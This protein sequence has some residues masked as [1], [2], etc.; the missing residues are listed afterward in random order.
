MPL[1]TITQDV[2]QAFKEDCKRN[3]KHILT[4][5]DVEDKSG[6]IKDKNPE[7][8][9]SYNGI[10]TTVFSIYRELTKDKK[11]T[12]PRE[13][14]NLCDSVTQRLSEI[15]IS[16]RTYNKW[17]YCNLDFKTC[18]TDGR[19]YSV[20]IVGTTIDF[21]NMQETLLSSGVEGR[22]IGNPEAEKMPTDIIGAIGYLMNNPEKQ[23][24]FFQ[25]AGKALHT[26]KQNLF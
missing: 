16:S 6:K 14:E 2:L 10:R 4:T 17:T 9:I 5:K 11:P 8:V 25:L 3:A 1:P 13:I 24:Q 21:A 7:V 12:T 26:L 15:V 18:P 23:D 20:S 22:T 19:P